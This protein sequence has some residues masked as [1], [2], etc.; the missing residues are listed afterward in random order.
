MRFYHFL[1][2]LTSVPALV[3]AFAASEITAQT[4]T[5]PAPAVMRPANGANAQPQD[6]AAAITK[7]AADTPFPMVVRIDES[8][9]RRFTNSNVDRRSPVNQIVLE[10]RT[11][12]ESR[13]RGEIRATLMADSTEALFDIRF[14]GSTT[15]KT[16]GT[17]EPAL[18]YSR[19]FTDF[20][21]KRRIAFDP[22]KGFIVVGETAVAG[23]TRLVY[24]GFAS[25]RNFG[26]RIVCRVAA[27]SADQSREQA[28]RIADR[29][30][31]R[32]VWKGFEKAVAQQ[33]HQANEG[34]GLV[35]YITRFLGD[36]STLQVYAKSSVDCIHIGIGPDGEKYEPMT[37]LPPSREKSAPIEIW[38][39]SSIVGEPAVAAMQAASPQS[40]LPPMVKS[41]ILGALS[42]PLPDESI[43]V[44]IQDGWLVLGFPDKQPAVNVPTLADDI[45]HQVPPSQK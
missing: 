17:Q 14:H 38:V 4:P 13:T 3:L 39:H 23:D 44:T 37:A 1:V 25:T 12:G 11:V 18:I 29:D 32:E 36:Q 24:D 21:C 22:R 31:K 28:R 10:T 42:L 30:S 15:T 20:D 16:V 19:T 5:M 2:A 7:P 8:A 26:R 41:R 33:I 35:R 43:D 6:Q 9:L 45:L 40:A 27:R 34:T